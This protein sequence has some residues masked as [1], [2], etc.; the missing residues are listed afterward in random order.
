M[1]M[2]SST[3]LVSD[4]GHYFDMLLLPPRSI[5]ELVRQGIERWQSFQILEPQGCMCGRGDY[6]DEDSEEMFWKREGGDKE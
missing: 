1:D 3:V 2:Y 5:V 6:L 4:L